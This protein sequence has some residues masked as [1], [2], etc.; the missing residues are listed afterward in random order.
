[1]L[2]LVLAVITSPEGRRAIAEIIGDVLH[3]R[4]VDPAYLAQSDTAFASL[5]N[6]RNEDEK[7]AAQDALTVLLDS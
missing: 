3:R 1:M 2:E 7:K 5:R 4:A 6:A